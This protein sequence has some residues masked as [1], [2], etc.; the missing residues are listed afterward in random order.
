MRLFVLTVVQYWISEKIKKGGLTMENFKLSDESIKAKAR[1][2]EHE[3]KNPDGT[4]NPFVRLSKDMKYVEIVVCG[5][6][7]IYRKKIGG[8]DPSVVHTEVEHHAKDF[9]QFPGF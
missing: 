1:L 7:P 6:G 4:G 3:S 9:Y 8:R 2:N 5:I